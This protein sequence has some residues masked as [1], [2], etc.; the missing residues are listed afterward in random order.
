M[1]LIY[2][3][4]P[5]LIC[6]FACLLLGR[7]CASGTGATAILSI[8]YFSGDRACYFG[9]GTAIF[10]SPSPSNDGPLYGSVEVQCP[11][12]FLKMQKLINAHHLTIIFPL[13]VLLYLVCET[14]LQRFIEA[15]ASC[16][17]GCQHAGC[18]T[19]TFLDWVIGFSATFL[20]LNLPFTVIKKPVPLIRLGQTLSF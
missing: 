5:P 14:F 10:A 13:T 20:D 1:P 15:G 2:I 16:F 4:P 9:D 17:A 19:G 12:T 7:V 3:C 8:A 11:K 18:A 6:V